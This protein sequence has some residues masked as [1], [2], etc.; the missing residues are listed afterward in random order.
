VGKLNKK[1]NVAM[2]TRIKNLNDT[3]RALFNK[4]NE[5]LEKEDLSKGSRSQYVN[6]VINFLEH[7]NNID[8][9]QITLADINTYLSTINKGNTRN[10]TVGALKKFYSIL[11]EDFEFQLTPDLLIDL[12]I[13]RKELEKDTRKP[14][15]LTIEEIISIRQ[16]LLL[17]NDYRRLY[18]FEMFY[19]YGLEL[20]QITKCNET[21]YNTVTKTF[22]LKNFSFT[23]NKQISDLI[24]KYPNLLKS[25]DSATYQ[26]NIQEIGQK[27]GR[28]LISKDII[29]TRN[30][31]FITCP[32]CNKK[33]PNIAEHWVLF[34]YEEELSKNRWFVCSL[35]S[36]KL[37]KE[38][39]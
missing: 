25:K 27:I 20:E 7:F 31:Y 37:Q 26:G 9:K 32:K 23:V 29:E 18:V 35:C 11:E 30:R 38:V 12:M 8:I 39:I 24:N 1:S 15:P 19:I 5:T 13:N 10:L 6:K 33:Y 21:S 28:S 22:K 2:P 14:I 34:E 36:E 4:F 16:I 3:T 17:K